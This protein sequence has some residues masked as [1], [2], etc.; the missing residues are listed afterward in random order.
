[1][2]SLSNWLVAEWS[3]KKYRLRTMRRFIGY[4]ATTIS[5]AGLSARLRQDLLT[6]GKEAV[7]RSFRLGDTQLIPAIRARPYRSSRYRSSN[8][9][10]TCTRLT[11]RS[12]ASRL[13]RDQQ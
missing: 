1:M 8:R 9:T 13:G 12:S 4:H 10:E 2:R 5:L 7:R 11:I 6:W 3:G